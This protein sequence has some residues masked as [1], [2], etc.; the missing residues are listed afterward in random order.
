MHGPAAT[1]PGSHGPSE[2][3]FVLRVSV[4]APSRDFN[5]KIQIRAGKSGFMICNWFML[6]IVPMILRG[7]VIA[8]TARRRRAK[9]CTCPTAAPTSQETFCTPGADRTHCDTIKPR[10]GRFCC[11]AIW[12]TRPALPRSSTPREWRDLVGAYLEAASAAVTEM[13][14][15]DASPRSSAMG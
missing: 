12:W 10:R 5:E 14:G 7:G 9:T 4:R 6:I 13:S 1:E 8:E 3:P 15:K 2:A 11:S